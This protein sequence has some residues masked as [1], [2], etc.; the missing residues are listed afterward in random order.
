MTDRLSAL[1]NAVKAASGIPV[2]PNPA[3]KDSTVEGMLTTQTTKGKGSGSQEQ[4]KTQRQSQ[5]NPNVPQPS[6]KGKTTKKSAP[7]TRSATK[8]VVARG[9]AEGLSTSGDKD[10]GQPPTAAGKVPSTLALLGDKTSKH[11]NTKYS[12]GDYI[13]SDMPPNR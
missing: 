3:S 10:E 8:I 12:I 5:E 4:A 11:L 6:S 9:S 7:Q 13:T 1:S 2:E